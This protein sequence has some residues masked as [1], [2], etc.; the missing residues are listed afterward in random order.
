M[1]DTPLSGDVI[2]GINR[3]WHCNSDLE[4]LGPFQ[5]I[6]CSLT[7]LLVYRKKDDFM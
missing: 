6:P 2:D 1:S 3:A 4:T 5:K 7:S